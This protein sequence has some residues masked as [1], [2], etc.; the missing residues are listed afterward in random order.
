MYDLEMTTLGLSIELAANNMRTR[1]FNRL[2]D[3]LLD[4]LKQIIHQ[5]YPD[6]VPVEAFNALFL[7]RVFMKHFA[8]NLT[9]KEIM[10]QIEDH[11]DECKAEQLL[12][13]LLYML[14]NMDPR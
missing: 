10:E 13:S 9:N 7:T 2:I 8:D 12:E 6:I 1:N 4:L 3:R 11:K 5:K 14:M